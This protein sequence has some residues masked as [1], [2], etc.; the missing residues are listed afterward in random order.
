MAAHIMAAFVIERILRIT[1]TEQESNKKTQ[2]QTA[3]Y[4]K[5]LANG[6]YKHAKQKEEYYRN[7]ARNN[8][9]RSNCRI[10][11]TKSTAISNIQFYMKMIFP[12]SKK[13]FNFAFAKKETLVPTAITRIAFVR[14]N[15]SIDLKPNDA[16]V[17]MNIQH[18]IV[19]N[20]AVNVH[21]NGKD[22]SPLHRNAN[23]EIALYR[24]TFA[25]K[26]RFRNFRLYA[27]IQKYSN[28]HQ[29]NDDQ[30]REPL[31]DL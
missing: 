8:T 12:R 16:I 15:N 18:K 6:K 17:R 5:S 1:H 2:Q 21:L 25:M 19:T 10:N 3:V 29:Q 11:A 23:R 27:T 14:K 31:N 13:S 7:N 9:G 28:N 4:F 20:A 30:F 26:N 24:L 22:L